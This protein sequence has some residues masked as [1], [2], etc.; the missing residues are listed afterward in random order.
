MTHWPAAGS[1]TKPR[2]RTRHSRP[3]TGRLRA[4]DRTPGSGGRA[5]RVLGP[6]F[7]ALRRA[8]PSNAGDRCT[9]LDLFGSETARMGR[10]VPRAASSD[11]GT[12]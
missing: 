10:V 5:P 2:Q 7:R 9:G 11:P 8:G 6:V 1:R 3:A 4:R 12:V